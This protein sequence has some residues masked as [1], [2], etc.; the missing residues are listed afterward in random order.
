ML[1]IADLRKLGSDRVLEHMRALDTPDLCALAQSLYVLTPDHG[2]RLAQC[3]ALVLATR[4][5]MGVSHAAN[6]V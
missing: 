5:E 3:A 1:S 4:L 2:G 6:G